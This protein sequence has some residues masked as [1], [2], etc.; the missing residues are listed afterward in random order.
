M[1]LAKTASLHQLA[2]PTDA[3]SLSH[4]EHIYMNER[5]INQIT[6]Q[7]QQQQLYETYSCTTVLIVSCGLGMLNKGLSGSGLPSA[8]SVA[9]PIC[10]H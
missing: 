8:A 10:F 2:Y 1:Q 4:V 6:Q 3:K 5:R 9:Y 7:Q